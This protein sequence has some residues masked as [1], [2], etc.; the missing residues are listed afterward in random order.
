MAVRFIPSQI[1]HPSETPVP[2]TGNPVLLCWGDILLF[3]SNTWSIVGI[4][5]PWN[6]WLCGELDE[7]Y[8]SIPNLICLALHGFLIIFQ[9]LF[10]VSLP[11]CV[12]LPLG[13]FVL[14]VAAVML[15]NFGI[16][17]I[18]NGGEDSL[19]S[20]V[21]LENDK[22]H[23]EEC[24]VF[25]NGVS[26]GKHWLQGNVNRLALTFRRPIIGVH[27]RTYGIIFDLIQCIIER[28]FC[29]PTV[30]IRNSYAVIKECLLE[31]KHKKV[32]LILHSQGAIEGGLI[33]DWLLGEVPH[34][35]MQKLEVYTFGSAANH[36]NNPH[37]NFASMRA[38]QTSGTFRP[39]EKAVRHIEHYADDG[40]FVARWGVLSFSR[41]QNRYMGR[42]F[43]RSG[44]G[45][46]LNQHYL[47][48]MFPLDADKRVMEMNTFIDMDVSFSSEG[49]VD[50]AREGLVEMLQN[51]GD[52]NSEFGAIVEDINS[53]V[54]PVS[55]KRA[56]SVLTHKFANRKPKV[57]DFSRLWEYRNGGSPEN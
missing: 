43:I 42:L 34:D 26:V 18:L 10:L 30:D 55:L 14:Y 50:R 28:N 44:M 1:G 47:N 38:A 45:H 29:Y 56:E 40:D 48:S 8:P 4:L 22:K 39:S 21:N 3:I 5:H 37:R 7:L 19:I 25:L 46:L 23:D 6:R 35:V 49:A 2:Y 12:V 15:A 16:S 13:S 9:L 53:P 57:R 17:R 41:T 20:T 54:E 36:F 11:F 31:E 33:L 52:G 32:V 24:W 51:G 27:N